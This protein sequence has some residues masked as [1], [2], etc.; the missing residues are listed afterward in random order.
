MACD[1][2]YN[3]LKLFYNYNNISCAM[4]MWHIVVVGEVYH[5]YILDL[6]LRAAR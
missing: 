2:F 3:Y 6:G 4:N 5:I 1:I